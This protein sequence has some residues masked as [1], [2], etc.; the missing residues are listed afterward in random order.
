MCK[1]GVSEESLIQ[2]ERLKWICLP[3]NYYLYVK[4]LWVSAS[5]SAVVFIGEWENVLWLSNHSEPIT[6]ILR[7]G[8]THKSFL[9][10]VGDFTLGIDY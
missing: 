5:H 8:L 4:T 10:F 1:Y 2:L 3:F 9:N 6:V 7:A